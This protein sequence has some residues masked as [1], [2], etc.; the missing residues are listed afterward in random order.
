MNCFLVIPDPEDK[1]LLK[2]NI[3]MKFEYIHELE[4]GYGWLVSDPKKT[5][6]STIWESINRSQDKDEELTG[7][8]IEVRNRGG[9]YYRSFWD[10]LKDW[11]SN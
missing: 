5:T 3:E 6:P 8:V 10:I 4:G 11:E 2:A 9:Y 7:V 1:S